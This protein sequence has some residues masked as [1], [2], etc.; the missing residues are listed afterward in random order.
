[1]IVKSPLRAG[2]AA[3][4]VLLLNACSTQAWFEGMREGARRQCRATPDASAGQE[5]VERVNR[6]SYEQ[7]EKE[8]GSLGNPGR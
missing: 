5:C 2:L 8:R 7:Y 4:A 1:M 3:L 6:G